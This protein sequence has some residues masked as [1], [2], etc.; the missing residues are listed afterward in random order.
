MLA[1]NHSFN[2]NIVTEYKPSKS[3]SFDGDDAYIDTNQ[4]FSHTVHSIFG[5]VKV[6]DDSDSKTIIDIRDTNGDGIL[7]F[8]IG[9]EK[10]RYVL[11]S[12]ITETTSAVSTG[13]WFHFACTY[14]GSTAKIYINASLVKSASVSETISTTTH[15]RIGSRSFTSPHNFFQGKILQLTGVSRALSLDEVRAIYNAG[16]PINPMHGNRSINDNIYNPSNIEFCYLFGDGNFDKFFQETGSTSTGL[17]RGIILNMKKPLLGDNLV[18]NGDFSIPAGEEGA[19]WFTAS[20]WTIDAP[21]NR[22]IRDAE[23]TDNSQISQTIAVEQYAIY[24]V[25]YTREYLSGTGQTNLFGDLVSDNTNTTTGRYTS[26]ELNKSVTIKSYM[27]PQY[28]GNHALQVY[29]IAS[30]SGIITNV[31]FRKVLGGA[32]IM[33]NMIKTD[34]TNDTP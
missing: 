9:N 28:T 1:R 10:M 3:V 2:S 16:K 11:N 26:T 14:D 19:G 12:T 22:A 31:T 15:A 4:T 6:V 33:T 21:N 27:Q 30:F 24:E 20:G 18:V 7:V 13:T 5:W 25:A 8:C 32:G 17:T 29:G 23:Q 34:L